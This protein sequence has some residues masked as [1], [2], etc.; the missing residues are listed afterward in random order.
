MQVASS[1]NSNNKRSVGALSEFV[2]LSTSVVI[3]VVLNFISVMS[4]WMISMTHNGFMVGFDA[5]CIP[6][7]YDF[8]LPLKHQ[9][10]IDRVDV[11]QGGCKSVI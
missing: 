6:L 3:T 2:N 10:S 8:F 1:D 7:L 9:Y 5:G 11:G 4:E